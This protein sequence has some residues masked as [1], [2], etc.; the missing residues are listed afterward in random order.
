MHGLR[1]SLPPSQFTS[2]WHEKIYLAHLF[3]HPRYRD[4]EGEVAPIWHEIH[5]LADQG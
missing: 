2:S 4:P 3:D 1:Y 5:K